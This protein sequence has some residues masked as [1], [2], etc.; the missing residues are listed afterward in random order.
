MSDLTR[1]EDVQFDKNS[2]VAIG[3][4]ARYREP[5]RSLYTLN[6]RQWFDW[7]RSHGFEPLGRLAVID[8][9]LRRLLWMVAGDKA[10]QAH[11]STP[12]ASRPLGTS[13]RLRG[14]TP[15]LRGNQSQRTWVVGG[16]LTV[17]P[18]ASF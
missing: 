17:T 10:E 8:G 13:A 14:L 16:T 1:P 5:T 11:R 12:K 7:C 4:L 6:L 2:Y 18:P 9:R 3:F 15:T